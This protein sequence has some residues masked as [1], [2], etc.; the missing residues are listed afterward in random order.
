MRK[1]MD[2]GDGSDAMEPYM[3]REV[4]KDVAWRERT[5]HRNEETERR[6]E[7]AFHTSDTSKHT[8][9]TG[10]KTCHKDSKSNGRVV[11]QYERKK[12][13]CEHELRVPLHHAWNQNGK[14]RAVL[15]AL[16]RPCT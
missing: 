3:G 8:M 9:Q 16:F 15:R 14:E 12:T 13:A 2:R 6:V 4:Y 5:K 10:S 7:D 1:K 11:C